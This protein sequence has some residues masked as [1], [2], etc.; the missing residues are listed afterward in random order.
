LKT[1]DSE[2]QSRR[3]RY[4]PDDVRVR[5]QN[6][7]PPESEPLDPSDSGTKRPSPT[8]GEVRHPPSAARLAS[9]GPPTADPR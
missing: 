2:Y 3:F 8:R 4:F 1:P 7:A 6:L 9:L 5:T